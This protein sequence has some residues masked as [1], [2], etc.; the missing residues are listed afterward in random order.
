MVYRLMYPETPQTPVMPIQPPKR[1]KKKLILIIVSILVVLGIGA[2]TILVLMNV[3][4]DAP[5]GQT[6]TPIVLKE[7]DAPEVIIK[8]YLAA[9]INKRSSD[10]TQRQ[11]ITNDGTTT[12]V[13]PA[14]DAEL[15]SN[16]TNTFITYDDKDSFS[17]NVPVT[18]YIQYER[19]DKSVKENTKEVIDQTKSFLE[20]KG[21]VNIST[22]TSESGVIYTNFDS[23]NVYCQI[24]ETPSDPVYP[25]TFGIACVLK[26]FISD[27]YV[28]I[29]TLLKL[30]PTDYSSA[31]T[32][33]I[34]L[35]IT[36]E[37]QQLTTLDVVL[38][39]SAKTLIFAAQNGIFEYIGE[40]PVTIPDDESSFAISDTLKTAI[41]D[42]KWNGFLAKYIK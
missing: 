15:V 33:A 21:L 4:K 8:D 28:Q 40:R 27:R 2:G 30:S 31:K 3:K 14:D 32:I 25:P 24:T 12:P 29:N 35:N 36:E 11:A 23:T 22:N 18:E 5:A 38:E 7:V 20:K 10:Y 39:S 17:T 9:S 37:T 42:P 16:P 34:G 19:K 41:N 26:T 1:S 13:E 6:D